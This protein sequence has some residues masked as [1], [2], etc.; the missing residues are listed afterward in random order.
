MRLRTRSALSAR[1]ATISFCAPDG[2]N[3][4]FSYS[5]SGTGSFNISG[6]C[7][8]A[9]SLKSAINSGRLKNFAN[10]V[11]AL[12]PVPSGASS[13]AVCVSPKLAAHASNCPSPASEAYHTVN[14]SYW[15]KA[16]SCCWKLA[17]RLQRSRLYRL[18]VHQG[19]GI[20]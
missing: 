19:T 12:Y 3:V 9:L 6:V 1:D 10:L 8:S 5:A 16:P 11:L 4:T 2:F 13:I 20:C 17:F 14:I 15:C 18:S 7:I